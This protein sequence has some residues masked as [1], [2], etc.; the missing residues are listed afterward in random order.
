MDFFSSGVCSTCYDHHKLL[1]RT[2]Y[3]WKKK[4][5][6]AELRSLFLLCPTQCKI[7]CKRACLTF[8]ILAYSRK[9]LYESNKIFVKNVLLVA[10][11]PKPRSNSCAVGYPHVWKTKFHERKQD[12]A[13][14]KSASKSLAFKNLVG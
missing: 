8:S 11:I 3:Q 10:G 9:T 4:D 1:K 13:Q 2:P 6:I 14:Y 12:C 7:P 5:R